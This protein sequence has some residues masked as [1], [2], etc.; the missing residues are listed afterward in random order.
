[1]L[2]EKLGSVRAYMFVRKGP[3][4]RNFRLYCTIFS[5]CENDLGNNFH[6][7]LRGWCSLP[8]STV[9]RGL[10]SFIFPLT[11]KSEAITLCQSAFMSLGK[12]SS[13]FRGKKVSFF[14]TWT[15]ELCLLKM[16]LLLARCVFK[17]PIGVITHLR[18]D[19]YD[20][21]TKAPYKELREE[22][23]SSFEFQL[24]IQWISFRHM[25]RY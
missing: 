14:C 10:N 20:L 3:V 8:S 23:V 9:H 18:L 6:V 21:G 15:V 13:F 4:F 25:N 16:K 17:S 24:A 11:S 22:S 19:T 7:N 5:C 2:S 1:M 12:S